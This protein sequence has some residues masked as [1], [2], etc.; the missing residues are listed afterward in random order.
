MEPTGR[1]GDDCGPARGAAFAFVETLRFQAPEGANLHCDF[2]TSINLSGEV[3]S[4]DAFSRGAATPQSFRRFRRHPPFPAFS[5]RTGGRFTLRIAVRS[6][7][8]TGCEIRSDVLTMRRRAA[9]QHRCSRSRTTTSRCADRPG[10]D[11]P[12]SVGR[13]CGTDIEHLA[14]GEYSLSR[15][16]AWTLM[17][18]PA[19]A[20][21]GGR[22]RGAGL[23]T[24]VWRSRTTTGAVTLLHEL[25]DAVSGGPSLPNH[26]FRSI[27]IL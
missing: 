12:S 19:Q 21:V 25:R 7:M 8:M 27:E 24:A 26:P 10:D 17:T 15:H 23:C 4:T 11:N 1:D 9:G 18:E 5:V 3:W 20:R 2:P 16:D 22:G 14:F 6:T 13:G